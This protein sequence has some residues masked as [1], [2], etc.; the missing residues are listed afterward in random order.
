MDFEIPRQRPTRLL[1]KRRR[2]DPS[3]PLSHLRNFRQ[4]IHHQ[5]ET[6]GSNNMGIDSFDAPLQKRRVRLRPEKS[7]EKDVYEAQGL[8]PVLF[9]PSKT[10]SHMYGHSMNRGR[11]F[12]RLCWQQILKLTNMT[13]SP[14]AC[15][16]RDRIGSVKD[17]LTPYVVLRFL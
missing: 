1:Q 11:S 4:L 16:V 5:T 10:Q 8:S 17:L 6:S 3:W 2:S 12:E 9:F 14:Q 7:W 13:V 15:L